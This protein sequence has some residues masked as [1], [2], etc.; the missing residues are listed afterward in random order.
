VHR[1][2]S[3]RF[4]HRLPPPL[5]PHPF[6]PFTHTFNFPPLT[7]LPLSPLGS[8]EA[9]VED[10][11]LEEL[12]RAEQEAAK[13]AAAAPKAPETLKT[14]H[15]EKAKSKEREEAAAK[16]REAAA[17]AASAALADPVAE[18]KR[19][20]A[21]QL[22]ADMEAAAAAFGS[23][24]GA[25]TAKALP[26]DTST[27]IAAVPLTDGDAFKALG[28]LSAERAHQAAGKSSVLAMRF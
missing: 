26:K 6:T 7:S 3:L 15:V 25:S 8:A 17:A 18:R 16:E 28:R 24:G 19:L 20:E 22:K 27:L 21:L 4:S 14:K 23:G 13:A 2:P 1:L 12:A 10:K 5:P 11:T 9:P